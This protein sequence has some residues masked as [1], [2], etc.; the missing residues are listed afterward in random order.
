MHLLYL[1]AIIDVRGKSKS[2]KNSLLVAICPRD[3]IGTSG[4]FRAYYWGHQPIKSHFSVALIGI[5][6]WF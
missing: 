5:R 4:W 3:K 6:V 1:R 2:A